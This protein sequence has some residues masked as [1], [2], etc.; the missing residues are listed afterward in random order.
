[1]VS[2]ENLLKT[3]IFESYEIVSGKDNLQQT[4]NS[5]SVLETPDFANY[6]IEYSLILTTLYPIKS[7][8]ALFKSLLYVL[9]QKKSSGLV[10]K[11]NRY[12]DEI[13]ADIVDLANNLK[14]PII[15]L[16]YDANLSTL[17]NAIISEI[18]STEY[19]K[20][21]IELQHSPLFKI[22]SA[23]PSTR[24]LVKGVEQSGDLDILIYNTE[25]K[26]IYYSSEAI[27]NYYDKYQLSTDT[28]VKDNDY[29][30]YISNV[31]YDEQVI[32]RLA[33]V[34][35][36]NKRHLLYSSAELYKLLI[37]FIHQ[38]KQENI[39]KQ[40]QFLLSFISN[41]TSSFNTNKELVDA[42]RFYDWHIEFPIC[43]I[44]FS[45]KNID[46]RNLNSVAISFR[47]ILITLMK[48]EK[49][50]MRFV[51][52]NDFLLFIV[53]TDPDRKNASL[54]SD[55]YGQIKLLYPKLETKIAY[56]NPIYKA[57]DIPQVF[58][59]LSESVNN[60][61]Y[62]MIDLSVFNENHV[63][64]MKLLKT[65]DYNELRNFS[66][67]II[68][69]LTEYEKK[70]NLPII[71]TLYKF[72]QCRFSIKEAAAEL[73]IHPNSL[74]YRL[75]IIEKLGYQ[76]INMKSHFFDLYLAL[77]IHINLTGSAN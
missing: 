16:D 77:Y 15:I 12:I 2:I 20:L 36:K 18:Q 44:L 72:I 63:R 35:H 48:L 47:D 33:L 30:I 4:V 40:N 11:I 62:H 51:Y 50:K 22:V 54:M 31:V 6:V 55:L 43:L 7:D 25:N 46:R 70:H 41:I 57:Q 32:Y 74:K 14:I 73:F 34:T 5:V 26:D 42:S 66:H 21:G 37:I 61:N 19:S 58:S 76:V 13:P 68:G 67:A 29:L 59:I 9:N 60:A 10:I 3:S 52:I 24:E 64:L 71:N 38:K 39:S 8:L 28:L 23:R 56:S 49:T 53:N 1:M 27:K 69:N 17:F 75:S 65:L 45:I